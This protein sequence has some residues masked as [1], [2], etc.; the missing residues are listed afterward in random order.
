MVRKIGK[1]ATGLQ[2]SIV[3]F[4][5]SYFLAGTAWGLFL[6]IVHNSMDVVS[7]GL[8]IH[9]IGFLGKVADTRTTAPL[10]DVSGQIPLNN[11]YHNI[12][13]ESPPP[14]FCRTSSTGYEIVLESLLGL[15]FRED[16]FFPEGSVLDVGAQFGEMACHFASLAPERKVHALDPSPTQCEKMKKSFGAYLP[17]LSI[18]NAGIGQFVGKGRAGPGFTGMN[19][20]D[21]FLI[22]T[23]DNLFY[24]KSEPLGFAHIDVEGREL[25]V[26]KGGAQTIEEYK[27]IFTAEL[28]VHQD[29]FY[30][31]Q[32]LDYINELGYDS[33]VVDEPCGWPHMDY[34]NLINFPR[35]R[36]HKLEFSDAFNMAIATDAIFLVNSR[37]IFEKIY[38]CCALGGRMLPIQFDR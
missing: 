37:T 8:T 30:S 5:A 3:F 35:N 12:P 27:P 25:D 36:M 6:V 21:K 38:P 24:A 9:E 2:G 19:P 34:R 22:E 18:T 23:I 20:G 32:L 15:F 31:R 4:R 14:G 11:N 29:P 7:R 33:Y 13:N 26:L 10:P 28:R 16:G 1:R 17:N